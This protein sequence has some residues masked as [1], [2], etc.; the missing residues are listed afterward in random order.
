MLENVYTKQHY[1]TLA[2]PAWRLDSKGVA[3]A[4]AMKNSVETFIF[5]VL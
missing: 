4:T 2:V 5:E 1:L 3:L